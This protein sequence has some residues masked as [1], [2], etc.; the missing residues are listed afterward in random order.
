MQT[1]AGGTAMKHLS[2]GQ[3]SSSGLSISFGTLRVSDLRPCGSPVAGSKGMK[4]HEH[5]SWTLTLS[6]FANGGIAS[7]RLLNSI[8]R[9]I[10]GS[11][12]P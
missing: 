4:N 8:F 6:L 3:K 5:R 11:L 2:R 12:F 1:I 9:Y 7:L 10:T